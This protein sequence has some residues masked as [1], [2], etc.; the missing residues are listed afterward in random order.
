LSPA[1]RLGFLSGYPSVRVLFIV[2]LYMVGSFS[3]L[4]DS[5][6]SGVLES[7][8]GFKETIRE[9]YSAVLPKKESN[10][11]LRIQAENLQR[12]EVFRIES[13]KLFSGGK[14]I[15][16]RG[17]KWNEQGR[18]VYVHKGDGGIY[19]L[20]LNYFDENDGTGNIKV[21]VNNKLVDQWSLNRNSGSSDISANNRQVRTIKGL[22]V[23]A[24]DRITF[25]G[26]E[27]RKEFLRIDYFDLKKTNSPPPTESF[28]EY[29]F[30]HTP[31]DTIRDTGGFGLNTS[32]INPTSTKPTWTEGMVGGALSFNGSTDYVWVDDNN[33]LD[34]NQ[35]SIGAWIKYTSYDAR[36]LEVMEKAGA[37][38]MN[39]RMDTGFL[40]VGG[41]FGSESNQSWHYLDT[42]VAV[43]E[44][45]WVH[46]AGSFDGNTIRTYING[47]LNTT[48]YIGNVRTA[49]NQEPLIIG[50]KH[51]TRTNEDP[52]AHFL[53]TIDSVRVYPR[54]LS[55]AEL[56]ASID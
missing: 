49:V 42:D 22:E 48:K 6:L 40:R 47:T 37:Y 35:W 11:N 10:S 46:V 28:L 41:L 25:V 7:G 8:I 45:T 34:L 9:S 16:L 2:A 30:D 38:W 1:D 53:G 27:H 14:A 44:N 3:S 36:R 17:G 51:K 26:K 31:G 20:K 12:P 56:R 33:K 54:A 32:L 4:A 19:D 23:E 15:S 24:G 39:V 52:T 50:A 21:L 18:A 5:K 29:R 13:N 43:P 55:N